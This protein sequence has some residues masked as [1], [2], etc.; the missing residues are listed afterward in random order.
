MFTSLKVFNAR[1]QQEKKIADFADRQD[2]T[3]N[4]EAGE[5]EDKSTVI[6]A[7]IKSQ[8]AAAR[9]VGRLIGIGTL[10][11]SL[12]GNESTIN[13]GTADLNKLIENLEEGLAQA[14]KLVAS[15]TA[16]DSDKEAAKR[17][18][19]SNKSAVER[20]NIKPRTIKNDVRRSVEAIA[21]EYARRV[22]SGQDISEFVNNFIHREVADMEE[23][24]GFK[25]PPAENQSAGPIPFWAGGFYS[26]AF[27]G[28][29]LPEQNERV[30]LLT[31]SGSAASPSDVLDPRP[32][33]FRL[34]LKYQSEV[35]QGGDELLSG[36]GLG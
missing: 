10:T 33:R 28:A 27:G 2:L 8:L 7:K 5:R 3:F 11:F 14:K 17:L 20:E 9:Q 6:E 32:E 1:T 13:A 36:A 31:T 15:E 29:E 30:S 34:A 12:E 4:S 16:E 21:A 24:M 35:V 25:F 26:F 23:I 22:A 19:E 18:E